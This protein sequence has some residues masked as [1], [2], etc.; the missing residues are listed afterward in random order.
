MRLHRF[1]ITEKVSVGEKLTVTD[2][3][4]VHQV[5]NVFRLGKGDSV[6]LFYGDAFDY[7]SEIESSEKNSLVFMPKEK[8][9][10]P[11]TSK[12]V[13]VYLACIRKERFEWA[14]EKLTELGVSSITPIETERSEH[15]HLNIE[16]LKKIAIEASEQCGRGNIPEVEEVCSLKLVVSSLD[17]NTFVADFGGAPLSSYKLQT[18]LPDRQA[19][20]YKLLI[21]PEGGWSESERE[22]FKTK[23]VK[24]VSLG[25]TVLRA[26]TA[27]IVGSA[28]LNLQDSQRS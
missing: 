7:V 17:D 22:L 20:N 10:I 12:E 15:A 23:K 13:H 16:R 6:I 21:G 25:E 18:C 8:K 5:R 3:R 27:A 4:V 1:Y 14:V 26:E 24:T 9:D 11:K 28:I 2:E 19:N